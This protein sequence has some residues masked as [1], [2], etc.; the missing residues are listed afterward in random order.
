MFAAP[1]AEAEI[2]GGAVTV[3]VLGEK[4]GVGG[5]GEG[6]CANEG[7][8]AGEGECDSAG[9]PAI[10]GEFRYPGDKAEPLPPPPPPPLLPIYMGGGECVPVEETEPV[11]TGDDGP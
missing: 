6:E 5:P 1:P 9:E 4:G 11:D 2:V 3:T 8:Y 10:T 7:E